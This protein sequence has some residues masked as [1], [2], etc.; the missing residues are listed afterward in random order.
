VGVGNGG[1]TAIQ[2][3]RKDQKKK[4][5]KNKLSEMIPNRS[6]ITINYNKVIQSNSLATDC[7]T[8]L[9]F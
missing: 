5:T 3:N 2:G 7:Q 6:V 1:A 4:L 9:T 8:G